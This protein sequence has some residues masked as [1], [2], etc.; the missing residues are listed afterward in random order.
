MAATRTRVAVQ[1][2]PWRRQDAGCRHLS[3]DAR[4]ESAYLARRIETWE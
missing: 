4:V 1:D 3:V 2:E